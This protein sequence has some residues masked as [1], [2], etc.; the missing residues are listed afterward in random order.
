MH[1]I[2]VQHLPA[3]R[4]RIGLREVQMAGRLGL[5]LTEYRAL[6]AGDLRDLVRPVPSHHRP[7]W[8]ASM[9]VEDIP[10]T[11]RRVW[12]ANESDRQSDS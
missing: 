11:P 9:N 5:T 12:A 6:E 3:D 2:I 4:E 7:L 1:P 8:V 10:P